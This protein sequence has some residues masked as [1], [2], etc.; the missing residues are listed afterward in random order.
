[1]ETTFANQASTALMLHTENYSHVTW[2]G[3]PIWQN[4]FDIWCCQEIIARIRPRWIIETG[5]N[6]GGSA[7]YFASLCDLLGHGEVLTIDVEE[8]HS[9]NHPR[10]TFLHGSSASREI[11]GRV[12]EI[13]ASEPGPVLVTLD[14][15][16]HEDHVREEL[17]AYADLVTPGSYLIVQDTCI[18]TLEYL[19]VHRPGPLGAVLQFLLKRPDFS[20]CP[21]YN[22][23]FLISHHPSGYLKRQA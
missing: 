1:M 15:N 3:V 9:L 17:G 6:R 23:K 13:V 12:R 8:L 10:I 20:V 16:H 19:T 7:L 22:G 21:E 2:L 5:T 14:S 18:D 11:S 4:V